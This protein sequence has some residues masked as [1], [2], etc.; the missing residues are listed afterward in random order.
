MCETADERIAGDPLKDRCFE[1]V[2]DSLP[3]AGAD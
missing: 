2:P 1:L 3:Q